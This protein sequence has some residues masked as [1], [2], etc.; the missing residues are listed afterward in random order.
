MMRTLCR[1]AMSGGALLLLSKFAAA[2]TAAVPDT[3]EGGL[4][5][6]IVTATKQSAVD[7]NKVPISIS[8]YGALEMDQRG[9]RD[10]ADIAAITPGLT[11]SQQNNFGT[12][13]TNIEIRGIQSRTSAP[14]TGIYLD[15]TPLVGRANNVNTGMNGGFPVVF[16]LDRVEVLRGP[17]GTLFGASSEGGAVRFITKQPDL[18]QSSLYARSEV[19]YTEDGAPSVETGIAGGAPIID[20]TLAFRAS[21]DYRRDGGWLNRVEPPVGAGPFTTAINPAS[22]GGAL[23]ESDANASS[24]KVAKVALTWAPSDWLRITPSVYYQNVHTQDSGSYDLTFSDPDNGQFNIAHSQRLPSDDPNV[25]AAIKLDAVRGDI[26]ISSVTSNYTRRVTW[27]TDYTQYQDYAFFGNPWPLTGAAND[28]GTGFYETYQNATS[29]ELRFSSV[30]ADSRLTWVGGVYWEHARQEDSVYVVHPDLPDLVQD[31]FGQSITAVLGAPPYLGQFVAY[32]DVFTTDDQTALFGNV[33][34]KFTPTLKA[35][36]G[37]RVAYATSHTFLHYDGSFNGGP[38]FF[39]GNEIDKPVTPKADLTWQPTSNTTYYLSAAKGYRVGGVNPQINNTQP[40]CQT[41]LA[42]DDLTGKLS[43]TYNPDTLWSYE[44]GAKGTFADN[45]LEVQTSVY[46]IR[47]NDI[48]QAAQITGCG[49]AAVFNLGTATSNGADLS[50]R[51]AATDDLHLNL[52]IAYTDAHYNTSEGKIVTA[53]D[54]IGGPA[55]STGTAVP[56]LTVTV[57]GEYTFPLFDKQGYLWLEDAYH[58]AN[59]GPFSTHNPANIIVYDPDLVPDPATNMLNFRAGVRFTHLDLSLFLNNA[60]DAH[61]QLSLEHTNPGDPRY[62]AVTFR[63]LTVG[64]TASMRF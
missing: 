47:W 17:Q 16:D 29:E 1:M 62:Q 50:L 27:E 32:D 60:L 63:P 8:A 24:T 38:G 28:Y 30:N 40:A 54:V 19:A 33:D 37:V 12:P 61:P 9:I 34:F 56:P 5:E 46:H 48:Q 11:F 14:T 15:D 64:L 43:R 55:I 6:V 42:T 59:T 4:Q 21:A 26:A 23:L 57:S 39:S 25:V 2:Q 35:S 52:Q 41:A 44:L 3:N 36:A 22:P 10:I 31:F 18:N 58:S 20:G 45:R 51:A 7:V 53:G 49:F 13:Q